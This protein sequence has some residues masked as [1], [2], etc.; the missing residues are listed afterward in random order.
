MN[1]PQK[2][3]WKR[4]LKI[5]SFSSTQVFEEIRPPGTYILV[6]LT[7]LLVTTFIVGIVL[8][9]FYL[10]GY[11]PLNELS[12]HWWFA[13]AT[14][15]HQALMVGT[16]LLT[17][18]YIVVLAVILLGTY[19]YALAR[20]YRIHDIRWE[21]WFGFACWTLVPMF[22]VPSARVFFENYETAVYPSFILSVVVLALCFLL[23]IIWSVYLTVRGLLVWT[24]N[25]KRWHIF[26][27]VL[28]FVVIGLAS[29]PQ[30]LELFAEILS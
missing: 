25:T 12:V 3:D 6:P 23:P 26:F 1:Q 10:T 5:F 21:H 7:F 20:C 8:T 13:E 15:V 9:F 24:K 19:Y 17:L 11:Q 29:F 28:P 2:H 27:C 14:L 30:L 16:M 4:I 18:L 22:M